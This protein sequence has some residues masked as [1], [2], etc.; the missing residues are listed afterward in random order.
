MS[1][2]LRPLILSPS[3]A[4]WHLRRY[5]TTRP[6]VFTH[7]SL[8]HTHLR[9]LHVARSRGLRPADAPPPE[10]T[11]R[12][13]TDEERKSRN[14]KKREA[15]RGVK[16][17]MDLASFNDLQIKRILRA[18]SLEKEVFDAV[19]LV[20]RLGRDVR[21]GK[22][23]QFSYIGRLLRD[24]EPEL[25]GGLIQATKD[26]D[27]QKFQEVLGSDKSDLAEVSEVEEESEDEDEGY[28]H[29]HDIATKWF[30]GLVNKD[31]DIT[32]EI[33]SL[34]TVDFD[35]QE[36]RKLVRNFCSLQDR[37]ATPVESEGETKV[38]KKLL[39]AE[40]HLNRFLV[41]LAKQLPTEEDYIL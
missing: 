7:P 27:M 16:W 37:N 9:T 41:S 18:V 40:K 4:T 21:E 25:I 23:R 10:Q 13:E 19:M 3:S 5:L 31:A 2:L 26:G 12:V 17:A 20:K 33:Y 29:S 35:R 14:E 34:S 36:L 38:D 32:S 30:N 8:H 22:R 24:V 6:P 15:K 11:E 39:R 28:G 1:H